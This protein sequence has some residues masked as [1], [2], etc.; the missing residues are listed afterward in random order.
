MNLTGFHISEDDPTFDF[1]GFLDKE[2]TLFLLTTVFYM[3]NST[4]IHTRLI[5][6]ITL[7]SYI[8]LP[9]LKIAY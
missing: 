8:Y 7:S 5:T 4:F 1:F 2:M 6:T 9:V 3:P